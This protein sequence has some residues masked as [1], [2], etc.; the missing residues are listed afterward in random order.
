MSLYDFDRIATEVRQ[1]V[2]RARAKWA[3]VD[4]FNAKDNFILY[5]LAYIGRAIHTVRN[6]RYNQRSMLIK[7]IGLLF[8]AVEKMDNDG[9][10][11]P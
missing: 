6:D 3:D 10:T 7:A 4:E 5:S 8:R 9:D 2:A 11:S 1:E